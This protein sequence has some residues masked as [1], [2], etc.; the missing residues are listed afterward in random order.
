[1][2]TQFES[3][4]STEGLDTYDVTSA[5][6]YV[7]EQPPDVYK[8]RQAS[9]LDEYEAIWG[10]KW[11]APGIGK[12]REVGLVRPDAYENHP[13]FTSHPEYFLLRFQSKIDIDRMI[14]NHAEYA[15]LLESHGVE[16][17]W[18][19]FK[20]TWGAYG[21]MRK[22]F[23]CEEVR[24]VRGGAIIP[25]FGHAAYKRGLEREFTR[26][27]VDIGCPILHTVHGEGVM[28]VAPMMVA[29]AEDVWIAGRSCAANDDGLEQVM[30]V[31]YRSGA[32]EIHLMD[33]PTIYQTFEAGGEFHVDM[34]VSPVDHKKAIVYPDNLPWETFVWLRDKG[35]ELIEVPR[36][37]QKYCPANLIIL[38]PGKVIMTAHA[39]KTIERV[40][41]A[42]VEVIPF[43][44]SGIMQGGTNGMKC[45]T[46]ELLRDE[47]PGLEA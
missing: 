20:N 16:I 15:A 11:G 25:R 40:R 42:G 29:M 45:I 30:S 5:P 32:K 6:D 8:L 2:A 37:E 44:G 17:Q 13:L 26:F 19:D 47:G 27:L 33:L 43:D 46:M 1:M 3:A 18:M 41:A 12:L 4:L 28:E 34:V 14:E 38:E 35:F 36:S 23:V 7:G 9:Y 22:L 31:M 39:E 21:P 10:R 24:I